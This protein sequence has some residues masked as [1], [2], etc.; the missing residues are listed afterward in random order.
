MRSKSCECTELDHVHPWWQP[1][2]MLLMFGAAFVVMFPYVKLRDL[3]RD[4]R[5]A[6]GRR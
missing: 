5:R 3:V 6:R 1:L 4:M 2:L